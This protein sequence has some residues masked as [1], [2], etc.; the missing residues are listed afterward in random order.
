MYLFAIPETRGEH[1]IQ[2]L[3][4][5]PYKWLHLDKTIAVVNVKKYYAYTNQDNYEVYF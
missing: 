4:F 1:S 2:H 3:R 5:Y